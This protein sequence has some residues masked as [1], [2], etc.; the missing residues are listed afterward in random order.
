[1]SKIIGI[2]LG[3]TNSCVS[4]FEGGEPKVIT[5]PE[6]MRTT[7]SVV[8]FKKGEI[9][10]VIQTYFIDVIKKHY[11]DFAGCATRKQ[12]WL[13]VL[14]NFLLS[15]ILSLL[16]GMDSAIGTLFNIV[17]ILI[18]LGLFLPSLAIAVRRLHDTGRSG[19]WM[20]LT[21]LPILGPIVL[22]VFFV[23]PSKR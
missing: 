7:P 2:D 5:N 13:Y 23:L 12:Y 17:Y 15:I 16:S 22:L 10:N 20:L 19:W 11:V 14:F 4:I 8:A 9:M 6:G 3:T 21:L 1:M 18:S